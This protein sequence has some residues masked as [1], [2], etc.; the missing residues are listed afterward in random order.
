MYIYIQINIYVYIY[1]YIYICMYV[2][3]Y[4]YIYIHIYIYIYIYTYICIYICV[5]IYIYIYVYVHIYIF[6]YIY[7]CIH[8]CSTGPGSYEYGHCY[9]KISEYKQ[10]HANRFS[11]AAR[12]GPGLKTPSPGPVYN[13]SKQYW[14]GPEKA[15]KIGFNCD[16]RYLPDFCYIWNEIV[17]ALNFTDNL[18][19]SSN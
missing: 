12:E 1:I 14:N 3:I 2:Y 7:L 10:R 16:S 19:S 17:R 9:D 11:G 8:V 6:I 15:L 18:F 4:I 5:C 13:I